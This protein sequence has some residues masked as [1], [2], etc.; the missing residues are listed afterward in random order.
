MSGRS[1]FPLPGLALAG[2]CLSAATAAADPTDL[3]IATA[4][5]LDLRAAYYAAAATG[6]GVLLLHQC[7]R[8]RHAWTGLANELADAGMHVLAIDFRGFGESTNGSVRAFHSQP[9]ELWASFDDDVERSLSF[10]QSLPDVDKDRIGVMGA[11]CGGSQ[12]LLT[13]LRNPE[14]KAVGFLSTNLPWLESTDIDAFEANRQIAVLAIA[15]VD[16]TDAASVERRL[17]AGSANE[18]SRLILYKGDRHGVPLFEQD[19]ALPGVI[20]AWFRDVLGSEGS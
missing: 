14:V 20:A 17:F 8:D 3:N 9:Q 4:D 7:N 11:S 6:P 18:D 13:S 19:P 16:D 15:A 12:A 10:L 5:G 2:A 1:T